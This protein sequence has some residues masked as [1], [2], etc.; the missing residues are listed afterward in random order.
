M[1]KIRR[2]K[3]KT[4]WSPYQVV[5][6][7]KKLVHY[8]KNE[9][10]TH[11]LSSKID[12]QCRWDVRGHWRRIR[13]LGR[14]QEGSPIMGCTWIKDHIRGPE[15]KPKLDKIRLIINK[16]GAGAKVSPPN[17]DKDDGGT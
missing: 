14:D 16:E 5:Y 13:G 1:R 15:D 9:I 3:I 7:K 2:G 4:V 10:H 17:A 12:W 11:T 6:R 8:E